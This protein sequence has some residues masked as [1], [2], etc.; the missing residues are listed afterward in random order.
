MG[1]IAL[2][3]NVGFSQSYRGFLSRLYNKGVIFKRKFWK[4][5]ETTPT[6]ENLSKLILK[7]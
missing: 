6:L 7:K 2:I 3:V 4:L 5:E 1:S